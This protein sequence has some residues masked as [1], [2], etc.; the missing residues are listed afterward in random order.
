ML[1]QSW[2]G[3][4]FNDVDM[5]AVFR[6]LLNLKGVSYRV[7]GKI[8]DS[9]ERI[10]LIKFLIKFDKEVDLFSISPGCERLKD[11]CNT[12][13]PVKDDNFQ[14]LIDL[15]KRIT[16]FEEGYHP[17]SKI[18][19]EDCE[20]YFSSDDSPYTTHDEM[21][22][23]FSSSSEEEVREEVKEEVKEKEEDQTTF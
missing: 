18:K 1:S 21:D 12:I 3:V 6:R 7:V 16:F 19:I 20:I 5:S 23:E 8:R 11:A 9:K 4:I 17:I 13:F 2:F 15:V 22:D 14:H 10:S